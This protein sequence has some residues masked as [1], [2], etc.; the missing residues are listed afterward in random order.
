MRSAPAGLRSCCSWPCPCLRTG[1]V[2]GKVLQAGGNA[3]TAAKTGGDGVD[4]FLNG[5]G[6][7][8]HIGCDF[9]QPGVEH[10]DP[11]V[12]LQR[13]STGHTQKQRGVRL[14]GAAHIGQDEQAGWLLAF[15]FPSWLQQLTTP[16][17]T[18]AQGL[19]HVQ[20][21]A[22]WCHA[23]T[24][25]GTWQQFGGDLACEAL[26][27]AELLRHPHLAIALVQ[28]LGAA[29]TPLGAGCACVVFVLPH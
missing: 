8:V 13:K 12:G 5:R 27:R 1:M 7:T 2:A 6:I 11:C 23:P 28:G 21:L 25:G 29:G 15:D 26:Q 14:H 16:A 3:R 19:A 9:G 24:A 4:F 17:H 10:K 20:S 18:A 22:A